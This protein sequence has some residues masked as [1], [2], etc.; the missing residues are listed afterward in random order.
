MTEANNSRAPRRRHVDVQSGGDAGKQELRDDQ[1]GNN[2]SGQKKKR[3]TRSI[4]YVK[5]EKERP[6]LTRDV[7]QGETA[8]KK[9]SRK[10]GSDRE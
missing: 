4:K 8:R 3:G 6:S 1:Q 10:R 2:Q 9:S 7:Q 5:L